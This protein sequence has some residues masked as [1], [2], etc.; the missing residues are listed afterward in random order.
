MPS[1]RG[2]GSR[3]PPFSRPFQEACPLTLSCLHSTNFWHR[4]R[5]YAQFQ[6]NYVLGDGGRS[7]LAGFGSNYPK[8]FWHKLSC[9]FAATPGIALSPLALIPQWHCLCAVLVS[10]PYQQS[11]GGK[12][13]CISLLSVFP[14][15]PNKWLGM[16]T[17][18]TWT[19]GAA[20]KSSY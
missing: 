1:L 2:A 18:N 8:Y 5:S 16:N 11:A 10:R 3:L 6:I 20:C 4:P 9:A 12:L 17:N 13:M 19:A 15:A 7:W 14:V